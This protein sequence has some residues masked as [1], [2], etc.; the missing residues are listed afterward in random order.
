MSEFV[1]NP[2]AQTQPKSSAEEL[3]LPNRLEVL[4]SSGQIDQGWSVEGYWGV[5]NPRTGEEVTAVSVKKIDGDQEL[6]RTV[7][8]D[9]LKSWNQPAKSGELSEVHKVNH[10]EYEALTKLG[11]VAISEEF[12][13]SENNEA[14]DISNRERVIFEPVGA[15][16]KLSEEKDYDDLV[17]GNHVGSIEGAARR[18]SNERGHVDDW[19]KGGSIGRLRGILKSDFQV[20]DVLAKYA[21]E[22]S[23]NL[24]GNLDESKVG[25]FVDDIREKLDLRVELGRLFK[26]RL[27][28]AVK[29]G[30]FGQRFD[31][32]QYK[33]SKIPGYPSNMTSGEYA[34]LLALSYIDGTFDNRLESQGDEVEYD[35]NGKIIVGQHRDLARSIL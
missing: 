10:G 32:N 21:P 13:R 5:T 22:V 23:D 33:N 29:T 8:L 3:G 14:L 16:T 25:Q 20:K 1:P 17:A 12:G 2:E 24:T 34:T 18:L 6:T 4:R 19:T 9:D 7:K 35:H 30:E 11:F 26:S 27:K 31:L 28:D 15:A